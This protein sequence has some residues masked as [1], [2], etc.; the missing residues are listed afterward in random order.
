MG[1][2]QQLRVVVFAQFCCDGPGKLFGGQRELRV[3]AG[4]VA[5]RVL[6]VPAALQRVNSRKPWPSRVVHE[7]AETFRFPP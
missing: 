3:D 2:D 6:P 1:A 7:N 5:A 4:L